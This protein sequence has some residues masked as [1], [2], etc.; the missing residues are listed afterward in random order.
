MGELQKTIEALFPI[1]LDFWKAICAIETPSN[2][3]NALN[4]QADFIEHFCITRGFTV[5]RQH[6][7]SAGDTLVVE[8]PGQSNIDPVALL[9]HMDT[10]HAP[11]AFGCPP[12]REE[13]GVLFG[14][15][16]FDCKGGIAVCLL[17]MESLAAIGYSHRTIKL[18]LN[19]D[20][21]NGSYIGSEG[22][23]FIQ[24]ESRGACAA[25]NA[26]AGKAGSLTVGRKGIMA[27]EIEVSGTAAHAGNAYFQ[28]CSA[29][30]EAA[31]KI[32]ALES[33]SDENITYNCGLIQGGTARN[34]VP[35]HC[36]ISVDIRFQNTEQQKQAADVV[37]N[38][39]D[40][41]Y[42][43]GCS[44]TWRIIKIRPAMECTKDNL[45]LFEIV[46]QTAK[47]LNLPP[48]LPLQRGGGS[49]SCYTVGIGIPTVCSMGPVGR[50]EHTIQEQA[51]IHTLPQRALLMAASILK[52]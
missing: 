35:D 13:N 32:I 3:Q 40:T 22:I 26:E 8:L 47:E 16:V 15:G 14:P 50:Y 34:I 20:E 43:N 29:I 23:A 6:Y 41:T 38:I 48:V 21:E 51:D 18:I 42:I 12:V 10:V 30:K 11:G 44:A 33:N 7:L 25:F 19:S 39:T 5:R 52:I 1:Y 4:H 9:A 27:V 24:N 31:H 45:A 36:K 46:A 2:D 49:D 37:R 17:A 28:G